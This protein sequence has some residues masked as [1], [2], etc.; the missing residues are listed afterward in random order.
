MNSSPRNI[1]AAVSAEGQPYL[2]RSSLFAQTQSPVPSKNT[3]FNRVRLL[4]V[5][6]NRWPDLGS[7]RSTSRIRPCS[8]L[9]LPLKSTGSTAKNTRV[10]PETANMAAKPRLLRSMRARP[11]SG[12]EAMSHRPFESPNPRAHHPIPSLRESPGIHSPCSCEPWDVNATGSNFAASPHPSHCDER[13][14]LE[15]AHFSAT[16]PRKLGARRASCE[17]AVG[18]AHSPIESRSPHHSNSTA[19]FSSRRASP[20]G[21]AASEGVK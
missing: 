5:K 12:I 14:P 16:L 4:L 15:R 3:A 8:R 9:K 17:Y 19:A 11:P 2:P 21:Y 10:V 1:N 7:S 18:A 20:A 6:T 13:T